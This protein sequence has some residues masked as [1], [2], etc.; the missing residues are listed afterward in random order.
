MSTQ[1]RRR[2][3]AGEDRCLGTNPQKL[4]LLRTLYWQG[5]P[6]GAQLL[7]GFLRMDPPLVAAAVLLDVF[8]LSCLDM[9]EFFTAC[10]FT[11]PITLQRK[12]EGSNGKGGSFNGRS[13]HSEQI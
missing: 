1:K 7:E 2:W 11:H 6:H 3:S 13:F 10:Q 9:N 4:S 12:R 5:D 8:S